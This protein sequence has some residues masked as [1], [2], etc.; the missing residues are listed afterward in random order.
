MFLFLYDYTMRAKIVKIL[1]KCNCILPFIGIFCQET[2][3]T[4]TLL[5][6]LC[7]DLDNGLTLKSIYGLNAKLLPGANVAI[8]LCRYFLK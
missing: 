5:A 4:A 8:I 2:L 7:N 6:V 1:Y 3:V